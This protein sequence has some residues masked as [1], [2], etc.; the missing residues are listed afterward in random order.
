MNC[1]NCGR[2]L[3][4]AGAECEYCTAEFGRSR[5]F[6][7][8][9]DSAA[10]A[11]EG[12]YVCPAC[13]KRFEERVEVLLP[14]S[15]P[16]WRIQ[17]NALGC[18]HCKMA[19]RWR[20]QSDPSTRL[21]WWELVVLGA[22]MG[23]LMNLGK[24]GRVAIDYWWPGQLLIVGGSLF[25][26]FAAMLTL[27]GFWQDLHRRSPKGDG[28]YAVMHVDDR[29]GPSLTLAWLVMVVLNSVL[30]F[31]ARSLLPYVW[32]LMAAI[33]IFGGVCSIGV[34]WRSC[35]HTSHKKV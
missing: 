11:D 23:A 8:R 2:P 34:H 12:P 3:Q 13:H 10:R 7:H 20:T 24:A 15:A 5:T 4:S 32:V 28:H 9:F 14:A 6:I 21:H 29:L 19:L 33:G 27:G 25:V 30:F 26:I 16:W 17:S 35:R 22:L 31:V 18:P 1:E